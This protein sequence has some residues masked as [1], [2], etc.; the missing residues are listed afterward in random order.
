MRRRI[1]LALDVQLPE[2]VGGLGG[3]A[4]YIGALSCHLDSASACTL[5]SFIVLVL[6]LADCLFF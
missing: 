6:Y 3:R 2:D 4:I 5:L 1:Q